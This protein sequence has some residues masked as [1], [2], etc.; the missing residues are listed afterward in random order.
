MLYR[1][2][3]PSARVASRAAFA[4]ATIPA[5]RGIHIENEVYNN[6]PFNYKNKRA[7]TA[8]YFGLMSTLFT[9][10]FVAVGYQLSKKSGGAP[11]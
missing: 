10:P 1:A 3:L 5:R 6:T 11:A 9:I 7:F 8:G 2:A 4:R